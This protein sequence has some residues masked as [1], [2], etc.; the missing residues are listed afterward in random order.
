MPNFH[1]EFPRC[2]RADLQIAG[3]LVTGNRLL[4]VQVDGNGKEPLLQ[5]NFGLRKDGLGQDVETA[6]A[7]VAIPT[8]HPFVLTLVGD[9][10]AA[11]MRT[12]R[13]VA[14]TDGFQ[15]GN[16]MLLCRELWRKL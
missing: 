9:I 10:I 7:L 15:M 14:P 4:G 2:R 1:T 12:N 13:R 11:A 8:S 3:Q 6:L 5:R 16:A